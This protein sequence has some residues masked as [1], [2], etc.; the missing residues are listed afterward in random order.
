MRLR[1]QGR[2][3]RFPRC[4]TGMISG[5]GDTRAV[6]ESIDFCAENL[7]SV[8]QILPI[9]ETF[10]DHS[11]YNQIS[12]RAPY[13]YYIYLDPA[14]VPGL[15]A[16][17]LER[18]APEAWL[19]QLRTG[20][21]KHGSVHPLKA[22]ILQLAWHRFRRNGDPGLLG[23]FETFILIEWGIR[24]YWHRVYAFAQWVTH[25]QWSGVR[26]YGGSARGPAD[27]GNV[28]RRRAMQCGRVGEPGAS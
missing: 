8:L 4:V 7:F 9:H 1:R 15:S 23:E 13:P 12:S 11:P 17:D 21:V 16:D 10:G 25:R 28:L 19:A 24:E 27:G 18:A 14:E 3:C 26:E 22:Q 20:I 2:W 5:W 6:R